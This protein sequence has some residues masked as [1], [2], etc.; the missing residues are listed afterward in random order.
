MLTFGSWVTFTQ[1]TPG[2]STVPWS[3]RAERGVPQLPLPHC[4]HCSVGRTPSPPTRG[5]LPSAAGCS[6]S[7]PG[8]T[9]PWKLHLGTL[10]SCISCKLF[11][12]PPTRS[13]L[14][15]SFTRD[16]KITNHRSRSCHLSQFCVP[17]PQTTQSP[18]R[19]K[20]SQA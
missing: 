15:R 12:P 16:H 6:P 3:N 7:L 13:Y 18:T 11:V 4:L 8:I 1:S 10:A 5:K 17:A 20:R 2:L 9:S 19:F 14:H